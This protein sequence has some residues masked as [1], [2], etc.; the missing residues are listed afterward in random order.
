[1]HLTAEECFERQATSAHAQTI[2]VQLQF[3]DVVF[4]AN[5]ALATVYVNLT[6]PNDLERW[7][8]AMQAHIHRQPLD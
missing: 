7:Q 2:A 8:V 4:V 6:S 3:D 1:L 5:D